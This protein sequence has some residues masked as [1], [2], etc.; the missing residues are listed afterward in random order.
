MKFGLGR[1]ERT[2]NTRIVI[3]EIRRD[4]DIAVM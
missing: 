2:L 4:E 1:V 3:V